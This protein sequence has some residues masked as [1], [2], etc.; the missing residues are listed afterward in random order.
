SALAGA[1][2]LEAVAEV[3]HRLHAVRVLLLALLLAR[4]VAIALL[5]ALRDPDAV[6]VRQAGPRLVAAHRL[7]AVRAGSGLRDAAAVV[8]GWRVRPGPGVRSGIRPWPRVRPGRVRAPKR[9][10]SARVRTVAA[11]VPVRVR[12]RQTAEAESSAAPSP[13]AGARVAVEARR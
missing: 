10:A 4:L 2:R 1:A 12:A 6:V 9:R 3:Q 11:V 5:D 8:R 7:R 13:L